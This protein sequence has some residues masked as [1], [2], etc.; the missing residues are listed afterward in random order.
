[1]NRFLIVGII[2]VVVGIIL[3]VPLLS[4]NLATAGSVK[5]IQFTQTVTSSQ[6]PG[7]GHD[8]EQLAMILLPN[9]GTLYDGTLTYTASEPVQVVILHQI[10]KSDSK[11][12]PVWTVDNNTIYAETIINSTT[13][14]GT[15]EFAGSAVGLHYTNSSQFAATVSVDGWIRGTT[16]GFLENNTQVISENNLKLSRAEIPV[17]IPLHKA[18][19]NGKSVY[20]II[21][22]SSNSMDANDISSKQNWKVQQ[23]PLLA[24]APQKLLSKM[25]IFTNGI[26][27]NGT[28]GYQDEIFSNTPS[29]SNYTPLSLVVQVTWNVGRT[30][31]ILNSTQD[32]L[33]GNTTGKLKLTVT[34][35][36]MNTPQIV[37]PDGQMSIR[38]NT[39]LSDQTSYVGGQVFNIDTT[40]KLVTFV[41]HRGWGPDGSTIYY[42][43]TSGTPQGP[44]K[45]MGLTNNPAL[46]ILSPVSRDLY[47]FANGIRSGGPF[48]F[49]EGVS[50][51]QLG[52]VKY[53]P[54][55][56]IS[57]ITWTNPQNATLL[58]NIN[59]I[60]F[61]K[62][63]GS[64]TVQPALAFNNNYLVDC[65]II[66]ISKSAHEKG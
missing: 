27:G 58:E 33:D 61:E 24:Q 43:I 3:L 23:S 14:G 17:N 53:S 42:I 62:S 2:A 16:P 46:S 49:Q 10:E 55:C 32:I 30:P 47:H 7:Q 28:K 39:K 34:D 20:Y 11:G 45:M 8:N 15:L 50:G 21:T 26:T 65:P 9:N 37:W 5:K 6:D 36:V 64:I 18:L 56:K 51:A 57:M 31:K 60:N 25:Y 54:I 52:D 48:G 40:N 22:D 63:Q 44:A 1:M 35:D 13:N 41:A 29:N 66:E 59:D 19:Y 4:N 12:Q 38:N